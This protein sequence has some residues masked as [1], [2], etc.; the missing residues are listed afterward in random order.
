MAIKHNMRILIGFFICVFISISARGQADC[1]IH[2]TYSWT[3]APETNKEIELGLPTTRFLVGVTKEDEEKS[4]KFVGLNSNHEATL[5]SHISPDFCMDYDSI[6]TS[7]FK[8]D[9]S[10]YLLKLRR[11]TVKK[12]I[13]KINEVKITY[14]IKIP[15]DSIKFYIDKKRREII[16]QLPTIKSP[17]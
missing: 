16:I 5:N 6:I 14:E 1:V 9:K 8:G 12:R 4:F 10:Y 13:F 15:I 2:F 11:K 17:L 3:V 7:I